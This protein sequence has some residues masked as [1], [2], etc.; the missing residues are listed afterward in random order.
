MTIL[1]SNWFIATSVMV[2]AYLLVGYCLASVGRH[3]DHQRIILDPRKIVAGS[4]RM[5]SWSSFQ[6]LYFTFI[7]LWLSVFWLLKYGRLVELQGDLGILLGIAGAG[8]VLGKATDNSRSMLSQV[9]FS[10]IR[11]KKWI[12]RDLIKGKYEKRTPKL[13]DLITTDGKLD[14]SRFQAVGF[15]LIIG[16]AL[17]AEGVRIVVDD[18]SA[19]FSFSVGQTYLALIGVSQG[20]YIGGKF[21]QKDNTKQLD[22]KVSGLSG[23]PIHEPAMKPSLPPVYL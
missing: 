17:L 21:S 1:L 8:T 16:G 4:N 11:G 23:K 20:V 5:A 19:A 15:T 10:W 9:N 7:V 14:I 2:A 6:M 3:W 22:Q 13:S 18:S 12:A